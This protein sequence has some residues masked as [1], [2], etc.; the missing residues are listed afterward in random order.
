MLCNYV[1]NTN[2]SYSDVLSTVNITTQIFTFTCC[3]IRL[4]VSEHFS[5]MTE[6]R[7]RADINLRFNY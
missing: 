7:E 2:P 3:D 5:E 1:A 6:S 4:G